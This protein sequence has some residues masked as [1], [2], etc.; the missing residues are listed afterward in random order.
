[1]PT[2]LLHARRLI[3]F[4]GAVLLFGGILLGLPFAAA[5]RFEWGAD[6]ERSWR[7]AHTSVLTGGLL[8]LGIAAV[9]DGLV[10]SPAQRQVLVRSLLVAMGA[11]LIVVPVAAAVGDRGVNLGVSVIGTFVAL[12]FVVM[13]VAITTAL[14]LL[15]AGA[16]EALRAMADAQSES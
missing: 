6:A 3:V 13:G 2:S 1:M 14:W 4:Y 15:L 7:A 8:Y 9:L 11:L 12:G 10:L 5:I 16:Y